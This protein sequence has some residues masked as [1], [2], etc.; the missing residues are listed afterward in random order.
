MKG[1][2]PALLALCLFGLPGGLSAPVRAA[3]PA[4]EQ[5]EQ[6]EAAKAAASG[7]ESMT[8]T[9]RACI[10]QR[11]RGQI[12]RVDGEWLESRAALQECASE[13]CP[14]FVRGDCRAWLSELGRL[15][16]SLVVLV[17]AEQDDK[18]RARV[19]VGGAGG[20]EAV[21]RAETPIEL[22]PGTYRVRVEL[23]PFDAVEETITLGAGEQKRLL[24]VRF[25]G[26]PE[27]AAIPVRVAPTPASPPRF[28]RPIPAAS[29]AL[30]AAALV[31]A[32]AG[33]AFFL[34]ARSEL[35]RARETC[36][37]ICSSDLRESVERRLLVADILGGGALLLG[38]AALYAYLERPQVRVEAPRSDFSLESLSGGAKLSVR[39]VF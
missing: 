24:R 22:E 3:P 16:P 39:G 19:Y 34:S 20:D 2:L 15:I 32:S 38:G 9:V 1:R 4:A 26:P 7:D 5:S 12:L 18:E 35:D 10:E 28:E 21:F 37:P 23:P 36:A 17:D 33:G 11:D 30:A 8:E 14:L 31:A 29:Y 27:V 6:A 25:A 13:R